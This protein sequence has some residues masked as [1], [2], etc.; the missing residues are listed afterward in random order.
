MFIFKISMKVSSTNISFKGYDAAP[1]KRV[2]IER[3]TSGPIKHE[4]EQ[5]SQ[6]EGFKFCFATDYLKW[7]Q[8]DK[9][10][11]ERDNKPHLVSNLRCDEGF[12]KDL[13]RTYGITA[14]YAK[15]FVTGGNSFIGK[16]PNGEKWLLI[17]QDEIHGNKTKADIAKEYGIKEE[18]IHTIPQ[19][20]YHLDMFIRPIG[21]PYV[22]VDNPKLV[23]NKLKTMNW[24]RYP[25]DYTQLKNGFG[26]YERKRKSKGY[27]SAEETISAL[28]KAGFKP[29]EVAG[30]FGS[31]IN[32]INAI[33]NKHSDGNISYITNSSFCESLAFSKLEQDFENE[34]RAKVDNID[35]VYFVSGD[36]SQA[37][38]LENYMMK[39][40]YRSGGGI[41]CMSLEEPNFEMWV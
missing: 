8:D 3:C 39:N 7:A 5:I 34:L 32:F 41:H 13:H 1:L 25:Y 16:L 21:Y 37:E 15:T 9:T 14:N 24:I 31:G 12:M 28:K 26:E 18:N 36:L 6:R 22:L 27:S 30:V 4:M 2:F 40:L 35:R 38:Y 29:I 10:I 17:G 33:V 19:Q 20:N 23:E 11:I